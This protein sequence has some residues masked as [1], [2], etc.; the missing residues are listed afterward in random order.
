MCYLI[1]SIWESG[2]NIVLHDKIKVRAAQM[3]LFL[4]VVLDAIGAIDKLKA[5]TLLHKS[6]PKDSPWN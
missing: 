2:A 5:S 4:Q 3:A 1:R 6:I